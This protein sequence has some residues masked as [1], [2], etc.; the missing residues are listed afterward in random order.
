LGGHFCIKELEAISPLPLINAIPVLDGFFADQGIGKIGLIG[1]RAVMQ[2]RL[3]GGVTSVEIIVPEGDELQQTHDNYVAMATVGAATES[4][5]DFFVTLGEK[6]C[7]QRGADAIALGGTD[8]FVV[9]DGTDYGY[10]VIDLAQVHIDAVAS[11]AL[12][13]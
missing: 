3:Y 4:Q 6:L 9:F 10:R 7:Q 5:Q 12:T 1:T 13:G 11:Q 8:L 2:S